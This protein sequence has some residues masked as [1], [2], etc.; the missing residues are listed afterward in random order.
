MLHRVG[1]Q[2]VAGFSK[3]E[4]PSTAPPSSPRKVVLTGKIKAQ[5]STSLLLLLQALNSF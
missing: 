3:N 2:T 1:G 4:L 5:E